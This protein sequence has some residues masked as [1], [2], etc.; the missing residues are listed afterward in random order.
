MFGTIE[1][2]NK[3]KEAAH[4]LR[5]LAHPKRIEIISLLEENAAMNV[6]QIYTKIKLPQA[7]ASHHLILLKKQGILASRRAG[8]QTYYF[9]QQ[10]VLTQVLNAVDKFGY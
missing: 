5:A 6:T 8:K 2:I 10:D 7:E 4:K 1:N 3:V 9:L